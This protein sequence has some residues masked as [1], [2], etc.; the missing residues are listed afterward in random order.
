MEFPYTVPQE[1][2]IQI[3]FGTMDSSTSIFLRRLPPRHIDTIEIFFKEAITFTSQV[4]TAP[5]PTITYSRYE[6][7]KTT[8][9]EQKA[10]GSTEAERN[11]A[12]ELKAM[13]ETMSLLSNELIK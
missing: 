5:M 3:Y 11:M 9:F 2:V 6:S 4:T 13:K 12:R 10:V 1:A 7:Q 8:F